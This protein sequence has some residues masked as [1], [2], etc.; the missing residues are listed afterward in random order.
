MSNL[1]AKQMDELQARMQVEL[2]RLVD[3]TQ[4]EMD[5]ALKESYVDVGG[6]G[7]AGD[8][9]FADTLIDTDNAMIGLHLQMANDLNAALDRVQTGVYGACID[10]D[11]DI[12]YERLTAYPTAKRC[13]RCQRLHDKTFASQLAPWPL[14]L[15]GM[16]AS[17]IGFL[18]KIGAI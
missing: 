17:T 13:I 15:A 2:A 14:I 1:S 6:D 12:S 16:L 11:D 8:E 9:A 5:P 3:G 10:C 18:R 7:D 4:G